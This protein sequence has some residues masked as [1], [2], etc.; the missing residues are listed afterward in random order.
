[1]PDQNMAKLEKVWVDDI[2]YG[3]KWENFLTDKKREWEKT[4]TPV[5]LFAPLC[6]V[7]KLLNTELGCRSRCCYQ[8]VSV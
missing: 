6:W 5:C 4:L 8:Q 3:E 1:M 7:F 2:L